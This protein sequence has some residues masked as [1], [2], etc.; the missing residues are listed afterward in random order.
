MDETRDDKE[1]EKELCWEFQNWMNNKFPQYSWT[2]QDLPTPVDPDG[3]P[4]SFPDFMVWRDHLHTSYGEIKCLNTPHDKIRK[5]KG[6][7]LGEH[8]LEVLQR[9]AIR[10]FKILLAVKSSDD[11]NQWAQITDQVKDWQSL[12]EVPPHMTAVKG[13]TR[14]VGEP[15]PH[16]FIPMHLLRTFP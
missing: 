8:K 12:E 10:G 4:V 7:M 1:K 15:V 11:V 3:G 13:H 9:M 14:R 16:R 5:W 6:I 2:V